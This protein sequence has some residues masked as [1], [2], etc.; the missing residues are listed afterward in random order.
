MIKKDQKLYLV[1]IIKLQC[2]TDDEEEEDDLAPDH[3]SV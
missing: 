3:V 2:L 1:R